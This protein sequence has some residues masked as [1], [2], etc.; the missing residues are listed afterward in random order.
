MDNVKWDEIIDPL[1]DESMEEKLK[2]SV[3]A[4]AAKDVEAF[5][6]TLGPGIGTEHDLSIKQCRKFHDRR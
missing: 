4:I 2:A 5:H 1:M 6:R 3:D